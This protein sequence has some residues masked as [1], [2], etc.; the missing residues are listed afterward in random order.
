MK[1]RCA[2]GC[3][4]S[5]GGEAQPNVSHVV[6]DEDWLPMWDDLREGLQAFFAAEERSTWRRSRLGHEWPGDRGSDE[7]VLEF[8]HRTVS[9]V[10]TLAIR[11]ESC[12]R[13]HVQRGRGDFRFDVF[14]AEGK[15][16]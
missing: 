2:C 16:P 4:S 9:R 15:P 10:T 12:G 1:V 13:L 3:L 6:R 11:C 7:D 14:A 5:D 8:V